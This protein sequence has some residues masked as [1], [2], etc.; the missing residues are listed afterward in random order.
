MSVCDTVTFI[1]GSYVHVCFL[2]TFSLIPLSPCSPP[3]NPT[4]FSGVF[5][6]SGALCGGYM[7]EQ[8]KRQKSSAHNSVEMNVD[9]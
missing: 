7:K 8:A 6:S 2:K 3:L 5:L 9:V 1:C 4:P